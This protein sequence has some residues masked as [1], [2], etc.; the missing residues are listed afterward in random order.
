M[1][2]VNVFALYNNA[3]AILKSSGIENYANEA[4]FLI[5]KV[6]KI[7]KSQ[8]LIKDK[9]LA[10]QEQ[11]DEL[12]DL[13]N[14]RKNGE[15]LQYILGEWEFYGLQFYVGDGVLV[16]RQDTET[17][18][19]DAL[20]RLKDLK[21]PVICDLCSGSGCVAIS[22]AKNIKTETVFAVEKSK[23][24]LYYLDKNIILNNADI[25]V[26]S[27][28]VT[29]KE[30]AKGIPLLDCIVSNP[31]YL[32]KNDMENL[33]KEV[34][35]E[36]A[37]ALKGGDDGLY[38]YRMITD[39]WKSKIKTGGFISYEIGIGQHKDVENILLENGFKDIFMT[40]DLCGVIRVVGGYI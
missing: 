17:L 6:F 29:D 35:F 4:G 39:I 24:A 34:T 3:K 15:P 20:K 40:K 10:T 23:K 7:K 25:N 1:G 16:P 14:R 9:L 26:V 31:P 2:Q 21:N 5:E 13:I 30:T 27:G 22:I 8:L 32:T 33:Q 38:F 28:D 19:D 11:T 37:M 36:P 18:V 12:E